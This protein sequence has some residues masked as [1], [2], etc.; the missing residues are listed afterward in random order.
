MELSQDLLAVG[1]T[2]PGGLYQLVN[3]CEFAILINNSVNGIQ[4]WIVAPPHSPFSMDLLDHP[5][6][7]P[8]KGQ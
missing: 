3:V 5:P 2:G 8:T 7:Q 4:L 1:L 6:E